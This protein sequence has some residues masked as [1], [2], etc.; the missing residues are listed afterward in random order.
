[1]PQETC[2]YD[3]GRVF[4]GKLSPDSPARY[5]SGGV[6]CYLGRTALK[7]GQTLFKY[8]RING[9]SAYMNRNYAQI[10]GGGTIWDEIALI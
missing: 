9:T 8:A 6:S 3:T 2:I 4:E 1:M 10:S 5:Y 7:S